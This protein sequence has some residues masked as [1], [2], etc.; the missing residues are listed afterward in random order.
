MLNFLLFEVYMMKF[1]FLKKKVKFNNNNNDDDDCSSPM[2]LISTGK[3]LMILR[4]EMMSMEVTA[5]R[6]KEVQDHS[7]N[8]K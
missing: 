6:V 2:L 3:N 8:G 7:G 1:D 4:N 5:V